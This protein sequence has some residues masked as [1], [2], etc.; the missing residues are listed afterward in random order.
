MGFP[1]TTAG[2]LSVL[3]GAPDRDLRPAV[4]ALCRRYWKPVFGYVRIAWSKSNEDAKD[5]T[6][7]FFLWLIEDDILRRYQPERGSLRGFLKTLLRRFVGHQERALESLKRGGGKRTISLEGGPPDMGGLTS[8]PS[9]A[10]PERIFE[11]VW[12]EGLVRDAVERV[13]GRY[14]GEGKE[15]KFRA[16]EEFVL[17][18]GPDQP[19]YDDVAAKLGVERA[20]VERYLF[21]I[22]SEIRAEIRA[23]LAQTATPEEL[24][25][26]WKRLFGE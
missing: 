15:A 7:A 11:Q 14:A 13:R 26:E 5:L 25:V 23:G 8:D 24:D 6:Q 19:S 4:E 1:E 20:D 10:D 9:S 12:V 3:G 17:R 21:A 16:Y 18:P 22:R 2:V